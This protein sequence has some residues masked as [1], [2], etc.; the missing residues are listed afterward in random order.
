[1]LAAFTDISVF[2]TNVVTMLGLGLAIDY[3][4]FITTRFRE[5]LAPDER[6]VRSALRRTMATAGRT[7]LFSAL[8]VST[9][10]LGLMLFPEFFLRSMGLAASM[11]VLM[12]VLKTRPPA[13]V[14][15]LTASPNCADQRTFLVA[16]K[17]TGSGLAELEMPLEFGPRN[18]GQ[19]SAAA[20]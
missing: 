10:L 18:W 12:A 11:A 19:S 5:E 14:G 16:E 9:S 4:L 3:A 6:D 13:T 2:T 20:G 7:V 1:V 8:T 15:E 17:S